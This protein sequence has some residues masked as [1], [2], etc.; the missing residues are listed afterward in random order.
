M[1]SQARVQE[2]ARG[3]GGA[4]SL[5]AFFFFF[6]FFCFSI[7]Q[8]GGGPAQK[9]VEKMTISTPPPLD[10]RL[11]PPCQNMDGYK[12]LNLTCM[13]LHLWAAYELHIITRFAHIFGKL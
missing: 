5:K 10:T 12:L 1:L 8:G 9:L 7:F 11:Y 6:F 4:Q 2:F 13:D 3:G